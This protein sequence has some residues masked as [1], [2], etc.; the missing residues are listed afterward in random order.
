MSQV[1]PPMTL[2]LQILLR[3]NVLAIRS[4]TNVDYNICELKTFNSRCNHNN[5][6]LTQPVAEIGYK[7]LATVVIKC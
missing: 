4:K 7:H 3:G 5:T 6:P 1:Q 2:P